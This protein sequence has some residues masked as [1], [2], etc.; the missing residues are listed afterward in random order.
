MDYDEDEEPVEM[1]SEAPSAFMQKMQEEMKK[2]P[3]PLP[4]VSY[5]GSRRGFSIQ[6]N[7]FIP[8]H[9]IHIKN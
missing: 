3:T 8:E 7:N 1:E 4:V 9:Y 2:P 6:F 5:G